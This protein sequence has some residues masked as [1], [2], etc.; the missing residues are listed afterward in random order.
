MKIILRIHHPLKF[1]KYQH[2]CLKSRKKKVHFKIYDN[3][4]VSRFSVL[5]AL[6]N[7]NFKLFFFNKTMWKSR[8]L[9]VYICAPPVRTNESHQETKKKWQQGN[10]NANKYLRSKNPS[11]SCTTKLIMDS[12]F[13]SAMGWQLF[14]NV[15]KNLTNYENRGNLGMNS[16]HFCED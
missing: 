3:K 13:H 1:R 16:E 8:I 14:Q 15:T 5:F 10:P 6:Q 12:Q 4:E 2:Q 9:K 7:I 11:H